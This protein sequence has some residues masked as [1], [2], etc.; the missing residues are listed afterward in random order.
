M[1]LKVDEG[2]LVPILS[3][4]VS[5]SDAHPTPIFGPGRVQMSSRVPWSLP[6]MC[7]GSSENGIETDGR[8]HSLTSLVDV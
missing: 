2:G 6:S 1:V 7:P 8:R 3:D 5:L 4:L